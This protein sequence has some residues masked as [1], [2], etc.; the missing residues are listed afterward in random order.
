M[1]MLLS[2]YP[3]LLN[4]GASTLSLYWRKQQQHSWPKESNFQLGKWKQSTWNPIEN[5]TGTCIPYIQAVYKQVWFSFSYSFHFSYEKCQHLFRIT[6]TRMIWKKEIPTG[7]GRLAL[8]NKKTKSNE[9]LKLE[10]LQ[11]GEGQ[12]HKCTY[13][14]ICT[15]PYR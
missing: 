6:H 12:T 14:L 10:F 7:S 9:T 5:E 1:S 4:S 15:L 3:R 2:P 8:L 11:S 13:P